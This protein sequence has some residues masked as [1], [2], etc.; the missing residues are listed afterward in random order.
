MKKTIPV[1]LVC[2]A[3]SASAADLVLRN[4][5]IL[6]LDPS[7]PE[8]QAIAIAGGKVVARGSNAQMA[9]QI[10]PATKVVDLGGRLAT[11]G[12]IEGHGHFTGVG[13]ARMALN[14]RNVNNWD[15]IVSM[16]A[17][18]AKEAKPG[19]WIV[20]R[21]WHQEKWDHKPVPNVNGF[22]VHDELSKVS[23]NN[24]VM[25]THASGH[26]SFVNEAALNAAG[27]TK[28]T[29]N[30]PGGDIMKD[31]NGRPIGLL[32][33]QAQGL[34]RS[35]MN[36]YLAR[37]TAEERE[38]VLQKE[39]DLAAQEAISKGI[40]SFQD[41]GTDAAGIER[42]KKRA[43]AGTLP[44]RLWVML[45]EPTREIAVDAPR[46]RIIGFGDD[47][48]TVRAI[49]QQID[50]ALGTRGALL[51]VPYSDLPSTSGTPTTD[52]IDLEAQARIAIAN[53]YQMCIHAIG[54][55][56]NRAV[57]DLYEKTFKANP[58]VKD[59]RWRIEHAQHL[60]PADIPR[61]GKLGVIASMQAVHA[62]SDGPMVLPRLGEKRAREGAY[63]WQSLMKSGAH[64]SQGTDA[65][66]EDVN[67]IENFYAAVTRRM[68]DGKEF[69]PEQKL[70]RMEALR[71]YTTENAYAAFEENIKGQLKVGMLGDVT[72]FSR[73]IMTIPD[74][75]ILKAEVDY[76]IIGGK[77]AY[78]RR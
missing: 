46:I 75:E 40:T 68:K 8:V 39:I 50:G 48:L 29:P 2:A 13:Q 72:V 22:P 7:Q 74:N 5:R 28:D 66:V 51:L 1:L 54:D 65:P 38:A 67:P 76:T 56:G 17:A 26:A 16:V 19:E 4:G 21:G 64:V 42:L 63:V 34:T 62:T 27:I 20:G 24:P 47:H 61:F 37:R 12:F 69:Y 45:R 44:L 18:A 59:A 77:V 25:L 73:D 10:T 32:N 6:T 52:A 78:Q 33:E 41:A 57:L 36:Q 60:D 58:N 11:P 53:G 14:L 31:A 49:K 71:S 70:S 35:A 43:A 30:P 23:P 3:A 55:G 15:D 9:S